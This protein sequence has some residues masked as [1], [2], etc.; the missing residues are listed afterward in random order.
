MAKFL[1]KFLLRGPPKNVL[2]QK[3]N[4]RLQQE[5]IVAAGGGYQSINLEIFNPEPKI[6]KILYD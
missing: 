4:C 2:G 3:K 6:F 5:H 1:V